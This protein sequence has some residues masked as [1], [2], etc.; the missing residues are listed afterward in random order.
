MKLDIAKKIKKL[1]MKMFK[2]EQEYRNFD[3]ESPW[4]GTKYIDETK[5]SFKNE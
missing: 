4:E 5:K 1:S 3:F 2:L